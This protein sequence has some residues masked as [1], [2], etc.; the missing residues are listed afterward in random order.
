MWDYSFFFFYYAIMVWAWHSTSLLLNRGRESTGSSSHHGWLL[1]M[2]LSG[3]VISLFFFFFTQMIWNHV[4]I[5]SI[6]LTCFYFGIVLIILIFFDIHFENLTYCCL[7]KYKYM[8]IGYCNSYSRPIHPC[9]V[10][11]HMQIQ[12]VTLIFLINL[13]IWLVFAS[14]SI[15]QWVR[16]C[17]SVHSDQGGFS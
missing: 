9:T 14:L 5:V 2:A 15:S 10:S 7:H 6:S 4:S 1:W 17:G 13:T 3:N 16:K 12:C 11:C 8:D